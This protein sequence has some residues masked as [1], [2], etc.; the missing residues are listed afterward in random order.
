MRQIEPL[1]GAHALCRNQ[2]AQAHRDG[3]EGGESPVPRAH[4]QEPALQHQGGTGAGENSDA[5]GD[6]FGDEG[7]ERRD[8]DEHA[9]GAR[10]PWKVNGSQRCHQGEHQILRWPGPCVDQ[11]GIET[12]EAE[13][14]GGEQEPLIPT[15]LLEG[16]DKEEDGVDQPD[17]IVDAALA[18]APDQASKSSAQTHFRGPQFLD[19]GS[20]QSAAGFAV[21]EHGS[22]VGIVG[23]QAFAS[24]RV[25]IIH[26]APAINRVNPAS[27][28]QCGHRRVPGSAYPKMCR[29]ICAR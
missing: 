5:D 1:V 8:I 15:V 29:A 23:F 6:G 16:L 21:L 14:G 11:P 3:K 2:V 19:E 13:I 18:L 22:R 12:E 4:M 7:D 28:S 17:E 24:L 10:V 27:A 9:A 26:A 20:R 25:K